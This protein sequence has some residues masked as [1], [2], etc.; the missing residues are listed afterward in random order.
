EFKTPISTINISTDVFLNNEKIKEDARLNRYSHIIKEQVLRLNTQ[1][2]KVLQLAKIERDKIELNLE[3]IDLTELI[4]GVSPS[5]EM[6]V[7]EAKGTLHLDLDA[8]NALVMA[9]RLHLTN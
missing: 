2:E 5:I 9:D 4:R 8:A 1:V 7:H 6:K 3:E